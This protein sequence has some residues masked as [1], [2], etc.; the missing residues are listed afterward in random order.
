MLPSKF[1]LYLVGV[2]SGAVLVANYRPIT[3]ETIKVGVRSLTTLR[4][5][6]AQGAESLSDLTAEALWEMDDNGSNVNARPA[7]AASPAGG[8]GSDGRPS[9]GAV[10][11]GNGE[12]PKEQVTIRSEA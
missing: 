8:N 11:N 2:C 12:A 9:N 3:K 6:A 7:G 10:V 4:R 1:K 5:M